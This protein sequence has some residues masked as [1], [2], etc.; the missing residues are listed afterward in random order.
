MCMRTNTD[1]T[2]SIG[3]ADLEALFAFKELSVDVVE[4]IYDNAFRLQ[5]EVDPRGGFAAAD[6]DY[7]FVEVPVLSS[8][9]EFLQ[10]A[11]GKE[12][13]T[14]FVNLI[15]TL[16]DIEVQLGVRVKFNHRVVA[17]ST[18][19]NMLWGFT[20]DRNQARF[21]RLD[22]FFSVCERACL[23]YPPTF[24]VIGSEPVHDHEIS[25]NN[26]SVKK[27]PFDH[28]TFFSEAA[29]R[30]LFEWYVNVYARRWEQARRID[31]GN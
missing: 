24:A 17:V 15:G 1:L 30:E 23:V 19:E 2:P 12:L 4:G 27:A 3:G 26:T 8:V 29:K 13:P 18:P 14:L 7:R 31:Q 28:A 21:E 10:W 16:F 25:V 11:D 6:S 22:A 20:E 9:S 5:F